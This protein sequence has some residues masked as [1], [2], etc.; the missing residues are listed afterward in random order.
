MTTKGSSTSQALGTLR[1]LLAAQK[2]RRGEGPV[3]MPESR[4]NERLFGADGRGR[5][6][7]LSTGVKFEKLGD[8]YNTKEDTCIRAFVRL[9]A[10]C[11][12]A[13]E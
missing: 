4:R 12:K 3:V 5:S 8:N 2:L 1:T 6:S 11:A 7:R 10:Q 13:T 9:L